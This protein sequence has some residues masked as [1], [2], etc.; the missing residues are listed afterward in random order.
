MTKFLLPLVLLVSLFTGPPEA[1]ATEYPDWP[2]LYYDKL[3]K[4]VGQP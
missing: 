2:A 1:L 4:T 3:I